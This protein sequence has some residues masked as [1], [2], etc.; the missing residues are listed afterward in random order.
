MQLRYC[1]RSGK[2]RDNT[3]CR[4]VQVTVTGAEAYT[5]QHVA[6]FLIGYCTILEDSSALLMA[7]Y[8]DFFF[9]VF[10]KNVS[11]FLR[12]QPLTVLGTMYLVINIHHPP[13]LPVHVG[14]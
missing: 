3:P 6:V 11:Q 7:E 14:R 8:R 13:K 4:Q 10:A 12:R 2:H 9:D 5:D 1:S